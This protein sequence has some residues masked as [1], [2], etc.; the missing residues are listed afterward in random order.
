MIDIADGAAL[1]PIYVDK[2]GFPKP[3]CYHNAYT[4]GFAT[5]FSTTDPA[6]RATRA[7]AVAPLFSSA[8]IHR[9]R[10]HLYQCVERFVQNLRKYKEVSKSRPVDLQRYTRALGLDVLASYLF[11]HR[12]SKIQMQIEEGAMIPWLDF[13]VDAGQF[14]YF[15]ARFFRFCV[16]AYS[17]FRPQGRSEANASKLVREY[18]MDL[19]SDAESK[20]NTFQRKLLKQGVSREE[21]A[22]ECKSMMVAGT[23]SFGSVLAM[24][25]WHLA[26]EPTVHDKLRAEISE[27]R[28]HGVDVQQ[29]PYLQNVVK[30]GHRVAPANAT[31]LPRVVPSTG[32]HFD[33]YFFPPGTTVGV[34]APQLFFNPNVFHDPEKFRPDRWLDPSAEMSR[35]L[36]PFSLGIRQCIARNLATAEL[37]MAVEKVV[38]SGVLQSAQPVK[39]NIEVWEW[40]N[41]AVKGNRIELFW[42]EALN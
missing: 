20:D 19:A 24:T 9:D 18:T 21:I 5:I 13:I 34:A 11:R 40:F 28:A 16:A 31:R 26:K 8:A 2:G 37:S 33:G 38:E 15:P 23:H 6:Y 42:P 1:G 30:E 12:P 25:L 35:D 27:G 7:K 17:R 14:F 36:V 32:W 41:V 22:A 10:E 4:D 3:S 29:L 39:D